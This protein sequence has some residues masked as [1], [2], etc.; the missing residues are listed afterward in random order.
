[1]A[2][3]K[4]HTTFIKELFIGGPFGTCHSSYSPGS[5]EAGVGFHC[6]PEQGHIVKGNAGGCVLAFLEDM[7]RRALHCTATNSPSPT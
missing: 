2:K 5:W 7:V 3:S 6:P 1:M 4:L